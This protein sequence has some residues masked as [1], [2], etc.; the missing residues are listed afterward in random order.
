MGARDRLGVA[1]GVFGCGGGVG[2]GSWAG[3][4]GW[5]TLTS[6]FADSGSDIEGMGRS[7]AA[8]VSVWV[9]DREGGARRSMASTLD[10]GRALTRLALI[11][12]VQ[13]QVV[14]FL[15]QAKQREQHVELAPSQAR[16]FLA[17]RDYET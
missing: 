2:G 15:G 1:A 16:V 10:H 9:Y 17:G 12:T 3:G 8:G 5:L 4:E 6:G 14:S 11:H 7:G 13:C